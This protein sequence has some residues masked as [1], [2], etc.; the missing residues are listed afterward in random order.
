M[1]SFIALIYIAAITL[2][3]EPCLALEPSVSE[4]VGF[5]EERTFAGPP[6]YGESPTDSKE[7]Q[8]NLV[9]VIPTCVKPSEPDKSWGPFTEITLVPIQTSSQSIPRNKRIKVVGTLFE[10][11]TAHHHTPLLM[12]VQ[13]VAEVV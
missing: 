13:S 10:A 9:L 1:F 4:L 8:L 12:T 3:V 2:P 11:H 7:T 5:V 6:N